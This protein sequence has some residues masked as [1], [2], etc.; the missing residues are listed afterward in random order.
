MFATH[1]VIQQLLELRQ[2]GGLYY[3]FTAL[4]QLKNVFPSVLY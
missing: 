2:N 1:E 4:S 3:M